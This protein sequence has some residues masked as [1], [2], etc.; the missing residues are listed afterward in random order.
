MRVQTIDRVFVLGA[1]FSKHA[2]PPLQTRFTDALLRARGFKPG[3]SRSIVRFL[4]EFIHDAFDH[5]K[6]SDAL[7]W[8]ELEDIF[9]CVDLSANS[10][11]YLGPNWS[12]AQL[13]T[14]RRAL[15]VRIIRMLGQEYERARRRR[16]PDWRSLTEFLKNV[17]L[18]SSAF[19]SLNWDTVLERR[20]G[21]INPNVGFT[22]GNHVLPSC[23]PSS[24]YV[25]ESSPQASSIIVP[26]VKI[27]GSINW[28]YCDNCRQVF[29]FPPEDFA[30]IA[31]QLLTEQ[32]RIQIDK[33]RHKKMHQWR[34]RRCQGIPLGIRIATFSY[35]K[36][37]D[38]PLFQK[39]WFLAEQLLRKAAKWI[40]VGYSLPAADYE[41][42]HLLKR[43]QLSR[44]SLPDLFLVTGGG[45]DA[46]TRTY[47]NYQKFFGRSIRKGI[48]VF[49]NGLDKAAIEG[50]RH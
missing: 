42:K 13:R 47:Q 32:E 43:V 26:V 3:P 7:F 21:E 11:H 16:D 38:F 48:N 6:S 40:F 34:C 29:W 24:G 19:V 20:L 33:K 9:T 1:G 14:V 27:H 18:E 37:L 49:P 41:F 50:I 23:F 22:Y 44:K 5:G 25:V 45:K 28:L 15:I 46:A 10:G 31:D 36:A 30:K 17:T 4:G 2:G 39:S 35:R 8:P 12:P